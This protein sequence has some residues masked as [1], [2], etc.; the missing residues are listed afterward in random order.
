MNEYSL[1][2][3]RQL[4]TGKMERI[5]EAA[6]ELIVEKGYGNASIAKIA[7]KAGVADGYLYRFH[8]SKEDMVNALLSDKITFLID[9]MKMLLQAETSITELVKTLIKEIFTVAEEKPESIKFLYVLMHDYNFQIAV[10]QRLIIKD[11]I[12]SAL[13]RGREQQEVGKDTTVEEVFYL[14]VE[15]PI[16]FINLRLKN[17]FGHKGWDKHDQQRVVD[18]CIKGLK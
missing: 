3:A 18:F 12:V 1:K 14:A 11:I 5:N 4:D 15:Y 6:M 9:K 8:K 13:E 16:V 7:K 17:F 2:M 10:E